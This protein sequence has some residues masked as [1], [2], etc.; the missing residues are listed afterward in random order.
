[1][2][3][4][5]RSDVGAT[6]V[7]GAARAVAL[8]R[9]DYADR[10][11]QEGAGRGTAEQWARAMFGDSPSPV[12]RLIWGGALRLRLDRAAGPE[13]IAGWTVG[14]RGDGWIRMEADG[15][16]L[17]GRLVVRAHA[18]TVSLTTAVRYR[19][20]PGERVW[21]ALAPVHRRLAPTLFRDAARAL[22]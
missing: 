9:V 17:A 12:E 16:L 4:T 11:T 20:R 13:T 21:R 5:I 15:P 7:D 3:R 10:F 2:S 19:S 14:E 6:A 1:M 18:G 8:D 22:S